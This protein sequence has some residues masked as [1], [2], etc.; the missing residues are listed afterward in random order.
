MGLGNFLFVP[1]SMAMG[2]RCALLLSNAILLASV[3]WAAK[4]ESF[5]SH[6]GARCLQ[7]LTAGVSDCL[8]SAFSI[9]SAYLEFERSADGNYI[10]THHRLRRIFP[11]PS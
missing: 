10:A 5:E 7:G 2:R 4:S 1:L 6:L 9:H 3:I 11:T 8:V